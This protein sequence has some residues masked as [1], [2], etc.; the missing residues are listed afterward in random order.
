[1]KYSSKAFFGKLAMADMLSAND[2]ID[3]AADMLG[4]GYDSPSLRILAGLVDSKGSTFEPEHY[5]QL[6]VKELSIILPEFKQALRAYALEISSDIIDGNIRPGDGVRVLS[7]IYMATDF[8]PDYE[9]WYILD[10]VLNNPLDG[11]LEQF[12]SIVIQGA[13]RFIAQMKNKQ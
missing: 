7:R 2:Y 13:R 11:T 1:M 12:D 5:F 8:D 6:C 10:E 3:W 9:E 4:Q